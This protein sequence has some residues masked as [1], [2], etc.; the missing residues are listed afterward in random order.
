M[1]Y[2]TNKVFQQFSDHLSWFLS[3]SLSIYRMKVER[4]SFST[5]NH[6][7]RCMAYLF[8]SVNQG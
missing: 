2:L 7:K 1:N 8:E 6:L 3:L 4:E 5:N